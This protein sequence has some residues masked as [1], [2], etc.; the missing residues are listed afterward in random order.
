VLTYTPKRRDEDDREKVLIRLTPQALHEL[1][2]ET[3]GLSAD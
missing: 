3:K 1:Y 2:I